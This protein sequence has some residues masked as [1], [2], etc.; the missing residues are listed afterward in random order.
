MNEEQE[1]SINHTV[2]YLT[3]ILVYSDH[4]VCR[5]EREQYC[6]SSSSSWWQKPGAD[7]ACWL[8]LYSAHQTNVHSTRSTTTAG[9]SLGFWTCLGV[10][11]RSKAKTTH[12]LQI[13]NY[14]VKPDNLYPVQSDMGKQSRIG[15]RKLIGQLFVSWFSGQRSQPMSHDHWLVTRNNRS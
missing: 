14:N 7:A 4:L 5:S 15:Y 8:P 11:T 9:Q 6:T 12:N 3:R 2:F 13:K 10:I 1:T